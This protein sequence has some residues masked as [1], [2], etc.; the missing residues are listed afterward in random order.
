[1]LPQLSEG[2]LALP[3]DWV[4][5]VNEPQLEALRLCVRRGRPYGEQR[6]V[7][8]VSAKLGLNNTLRRRG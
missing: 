8:R 3:K 6:W 2:P 1:M 4:K 7:E 5:L